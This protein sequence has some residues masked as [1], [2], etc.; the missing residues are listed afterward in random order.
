MLLLIARAKFSNFNR[1]IIAK[2][3]T[4]FL[5]KNAK[6]NTLNEVYSEMLKPQTRYLTLAEAVKLYDTKLSTFEHQEIQNYSHVYF[7]GQ[8]AN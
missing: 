7:V 4:W 8:H 2:I 1:V 6:I 5:L 3:G